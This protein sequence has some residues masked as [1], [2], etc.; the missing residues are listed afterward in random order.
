[1]SNSTEAAPATPVTS[2]TPKPVL[3]LNDVSKSFGPIEVLHNNSLAL[4][5]GS[6]TAIVGENGAGKSTFIKVISGAEA[7]TTGNVF[8]GGKQ[9]PPNPGRVIEAGVSVIYQE[10]TDMPEMSLGDNV[11]L[12]RQ[13]STMGLVRRRMADGIAREALARVG[14]G[15]ISL[16]RPMRELSIAQ[17]Q[18]AE[19]ARCLTR[20]TKVLV[21]DEPTSS[22]AEGDVEALLDT[23]TA[24]RSE[25]LAILYVSHH[26][27][28][29]FRIADRIAVL[30]DGS[31]VDTR[32]TPEWTEKSLVRVM[33]GRDL[34]NA[35]P[36]REREVSGTRLA[37]KSLTGSGYSNASLT[38]G[39][40]EIVG[41]LG[42][43][44]S[45]HRE[46]VRGIAGV[47]RPTGGSVEVDGLAARKGGLNSLRRQGVI[48]S[49]MDRKIEG[50][51]LD[52]AVED[53]LIY[54]L[55]PK[56][57]VAGV[58]STAR[59]R[60][61]ARNAIAKFGIKTSSPRLHV[62]RLSGGNQQKVVLARLAE[63]NPVVALL[64]DPTR[65]VDVGARAS[66]HD[67]ILS[68]AE[69]GTA[70]ILTSS[71]SD[72]VMAMTDRLY[73]VRAG[74]VVAARLRADYDRDEILHLAAAG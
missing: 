35:F 24:L 57:S 20:D 13:P 4:M 55:Y 18:L 19:I 74:R 26:L 17:R 68:M 37:V 2:A 46:L 6:I 66:I 53:N 16:R 47:S 45:G 62:G 22:L 40:G 63:N 25:G 9:V 43:D 51:T 42:L 58:L 21:L 60:R 39:A 11:L 28:E 34:E 15:H 65:G 1:M 3:E 73:I 48:Y 49:P 27:D 59:K 12:G 7:P 72:E 14:M 56:V 52:A 64:D 29:V 38:V 44:G 23:L 54:G 10:L 33:I 8:I 31:V 70:V 41:V 32:P 50:L 36:W 67:H 5:P 30:R 61:L 69:T 71:D